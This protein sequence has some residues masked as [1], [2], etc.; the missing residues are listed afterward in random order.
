MSDLKQQRAELVE[1]FQIND[2]DTGSPEV[3]IALLTQRILELTEHMKQHPKD[4][5][6]RR[7]LIRMVQ[8]RKK[9]LRYLMNNHYERYEKITEELGL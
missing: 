7:G 9:N 6:T 5:S 3:Q 1:E 4:F 8:R 2:K